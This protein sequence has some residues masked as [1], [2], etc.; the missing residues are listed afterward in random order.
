MFSRYDGI[1]RFSAAMVFSALATGPLSFLTKGMLGSVTFYVL[2]WA[3]GW[4]ASKGI[5]LLNLGVD[6]I[7]VEM[8]K[9]TYVEVME[10]ALAQVR[11][12]KGRLSKEDKKRIDDKVKLAFKSF[13]TFI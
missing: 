2:R 7:Q 9:R 5:V 11:A 12:S 8:E 10:E 1:A 3:S 13:V 6:Y 4:A